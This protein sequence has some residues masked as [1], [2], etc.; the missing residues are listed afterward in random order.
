MRS[1]ILINKTTTEIENFLY[2]NRLIYTP[3]LMRFMNC[4][5]RQAFKI[6]KYVKEKY[7]VKVDGIPSE[8]FRLFIENM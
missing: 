2:E 8:I 6:I 7:H 3:T 1:R 5:Y 4:S